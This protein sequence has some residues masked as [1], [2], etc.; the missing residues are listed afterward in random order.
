[1]PP[2]NAAA[3]VSFLGVPIH[4]GALSLVTLTLQNSALTIVLHYVS[5]NEACTRSQVACSSCGVP[6]SRLRFPKSPVSNQRTSGQDVQCSISSIYQRVLERSD[7][8]VYRVVQR[9][10]EPSYVQWEW[11]QRRARP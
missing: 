7:L 1:M 6:L 11:V 4:L 10:Q 8:T 3:Q 2:P 5:L 9:A